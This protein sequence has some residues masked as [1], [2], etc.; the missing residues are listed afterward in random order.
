MLG[1]EA[2]TY[3]RI[4]GLGINIDVNELIQESSKYKAQGPRCVIE[5]LLRMV[6]EKHGK[7]ESIK[8][9]VIIDNAEIGTQTMRDFLFKNG[10]EISVWQIRYHRKRIRGT[11]CR[12]DYVRVQ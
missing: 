10:Y 3:E 5:R 2:T 1:F 6:E 11:G 12:C 8:L 7:E 4:R 9:A